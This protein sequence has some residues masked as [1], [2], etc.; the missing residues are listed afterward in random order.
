MSSFCS[1]S[2]EKMSRLSGTVATPARAMASGR[3]PTMSRRRN[4][5]SPQREVSQ[6]GQE[7][8]RRGQPWP[9]DG[10]LAG[11]VHVVDADDTAG[12][13]LSSVGTNWNVIQGRLRA[14]AS[15]GTGPGRRRSPFSRAGSSERRTRRFCR[16]AS[17]PPGRARRSPT[18][19]RFF[20]VHGRQKGSFPSRESPGSVVV[21]FRGVAAFI[22]A[23]HT[24]NGSVR[25]RTDGTDSPAHAD[26]D[27]CGRCIHC[28]GAPAWGRY[29][30]AGHRTG[31]A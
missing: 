25:R 9:R 23:R 12:S 13:A 30:H 20:P 15:A 14:K 22:A 11:D 21:S 3:K 8:M 4:G 17:R 19:R 24:R 16:I 29:G 27:T 1:V 7:G 5:S 18:R 28:D 31:T 2:V 10:G 6:K 26:F